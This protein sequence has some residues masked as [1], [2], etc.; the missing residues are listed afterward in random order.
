M[1][2]VD[3]PG[4]QSFG[5]VVPLTRRLRIPGLPIPSNRRMPASISFANSAATEGVNGRTGT[6]TVRRR[7]TPCPFSSRLKVAPNWAD[8]RNAAGP[9]G[10]APKNSL[11]MS[12]RPVSVCPVWSW[13]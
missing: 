5:F 4:G 10:I 9:G 7:A 12:S 8:S 11:W 1:T 3:D 6:V 2:R 13:L